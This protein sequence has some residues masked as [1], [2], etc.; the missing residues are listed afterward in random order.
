MA[1]RIWTMSA[2]E[3]SRGGGMAAG[4]KENG[5]GAE[6]GGAAAASV[7]ATKGCGKPASMAC[8]KCIE[9]KLP[10]ALFCSQVCVYVH[11]CV[12][13]GR[14]SDRAS[15]RVRECYARTPDP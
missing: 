11:V 12:V 2:F 3:D 13:R 7:C 1:T 4:G 10:V 5:G 8:P 9:M 15:A 6:D 14:A